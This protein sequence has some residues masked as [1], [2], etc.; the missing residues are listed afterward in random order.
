MKRLVL[1]AAMLAAWAGCVPPQEEEPA[2]VIP[3]L[4]DVGACQLQVKV[5]EVEPIDAY[6]EIEGFLFPAMTPVGSVV[7]ATPEDRFVCLN[8]YPE[9]TEVFFVMTTYNPATGA[10]KHVRWFGKTP[11]KGEEPPPID[12]PVG[13]QPTG[14]E[15]SVAV[16]GDGLAEGQTLT[17]MEQNF[18]LV[19]TVNGTGTQEVF[20]TFPAD[21]PRSAFT[22]VV[23]VFNSA[24][25]LVANPGI[26]AGN[27][28]FSVTFPGPG[29]Y[30]IKGQWVLN[31]GTGTVTYGIPA[32]DPSRGVEVS[33]VA[34]N[35][36][37]PQVCQPSELEL[38]VAVPA[39]G[40]VENVMGK[41]LQGAAQTFHLRDLLPGGALGDVFATFPSCLP[42]TAFAPWVEILNGSG[43]SVWSQTLTGG[44]T[45]F[46]FTFGASGSYKIRGHWDLDLGS[47]TATYGIPATDWVNGVSF[48]VQI[49]QPPQVCQ[50]SEL[51]L[52]VAV[53]A[54]GGVENVMGKT[55]QG[56]A[57]TFHLRDL[58]PGGALG[59][60]FAT[61]PSC[62]PHTAFTPTV[63]VENSSQAIVWQ[64]TL[65]GTTSFS[66]TFSASGSYKIR[67]WWSLPIGGG[68]T[69]EFGIP[70]D[71]P[72]LG[73]QFTVNIPQ[74]QAGL[75]ADLDM[76]VAVHDGGGWVNAEGMTLA[77]LSQTFKL[78][79]YVSDTQVRLVSETFPSGFPASLFDPTVEVLNLMGAVVWS[80]QLSAGTY[81]FTVPFPSPG[82][83][84][85]RGEW[86]V[87]A[88]NGQSTIF[89]IPWI[90]PGRGTEVSVV[91]Q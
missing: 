36:P 21:L 78:M 65:G 19:D 9:C 1:A 39:G 87:T 54:G 32:I 57:Q 51:E 6:I 37:P 47:A 7:T 46:S 24:G 56:A 52:V 20:A 25:G 13:P 45:S 76:V 27:T 30:Y 17:G 73:V 11:C 82:V 42:H 10:P 53:P 18:L 12:P 77:G 55:L 33:V 2:P 16:A 70:A 75:P 90:D 40:G 38:V 4:P 58:L 48:T 23:Q 68:S 34:G 59:D 86:D 8:G 88:P 66:V 14:L 85:I 3:S 22:P 41:T 35:D 91:V 63:Q 89:Y 71:N 62:L 49:S 64:Q 5:E 29:V 44:S 61:F 26:G 43:Q 72:G 69:A 60:V 74:Q 83:Y 50:P 31:V 81:T 28:A 67:G 15:I 84:R 80:T 79:D